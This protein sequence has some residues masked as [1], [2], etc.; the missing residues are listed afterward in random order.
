MLEHSDIPRLNTLHSDGTSMHAPDAFGSPA[1]LSANCAASVN[2]RQPFQANVKAGLPVLMAS[3]TCRRER[4][5]QGRPG[6]MTA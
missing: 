2:V 3:N 6:D 4:A 5:C 1:C